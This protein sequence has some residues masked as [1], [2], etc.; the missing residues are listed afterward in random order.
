MIRVF[1]F[2]QRIPFELVYTT[3]MSSETNDNKVNLNIPLNFVLQYN[4]FYHNP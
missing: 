3:G 1:D 2:S 4:M